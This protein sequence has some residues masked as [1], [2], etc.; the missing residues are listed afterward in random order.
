MR[1]RINKTVQ[2]N[3]EACACAL[4][5]L[6]LFGVGATFA[7]VKTRIQLNK[8]NKALIRCKT[9]MREFFNEWKNED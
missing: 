1:E 9:K 7:Y 5:G 3:P 4:G 8:S 2:N 6:F